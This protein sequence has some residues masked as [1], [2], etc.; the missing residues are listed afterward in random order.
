MLKNYDIVIVGGGPTGS[1]ASLLLAEKGLKIALIERNSQPYPHPRAIALN[2][3][4]L[5]IIKHL[6]DDQWENFEF[7]TAVEVGYVLSKDKMDE[8]FGKMQPPVIDGKVLDL[9]NYGFLNWFNQPQLEGLLRLKME[10]NS[11]IDCYYNHSAIVMYEDDKNYLKIQ[12][13][14][15]NAIAEISS[16]YLIGADGGGSFIRKQMGA[17]LTTLGKAISFLVVDIES[18]RD[19]LRPGK[20]FDSGGHQIIDPIGKRPTTFIHTPGKKHGTYKKHFRF[21]FALKENENFAQLQSPSSIEELVTPYLDPKKITINRSTVYKFNSL[22]SEKWR[23]NNIFTIGDASHQTSP[24]IGQ[25]LN[26][27]IRNTCNLVHKINL[28]EKGISK[29]NLLDNYQVECYPDSRFIIKQSLF[30]GGMLFNI[31]PH[32]NLI[33]SIVHMFNGKRGKPLDLFPA[34]VPETITVPNGF[35]PTK[36]SQ[37][38][39]PMFNYITEK[40]FPRSLRTY[41]PTHYRILCNNCSENVQSFVDDLPQEI[42][43]FVVNLCDG[44]KGEKSTEKLLVSSQRAEDLKTYKRLFKGADYVL[45]APGYTML[46]TYKLGSESKLVADYKSLFCLIG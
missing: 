40:G 29:P 26:L 17:K 25:G 13:H 20:S 42:K 35:N 39:Y 41:N 44:Q 9:D 24:F 14:D 5:S 33:R 46:G 32:I 12:N 37:K 27:G 21:E 31:K 34:F 2:G 11:N 4:S 45:M 16:K 1:I 15:N 6:L 36:S 19:A 3:Y 18:S 7:T 8:P 30:M 22:I 10:S 38:G 28:V 43:P 23:S